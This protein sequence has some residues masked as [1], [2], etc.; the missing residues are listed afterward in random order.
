MC[1]YQLGRNILASGQG[2]F[3]YV[4]EGNEASARML[5]GLGFRSRAEP[6]V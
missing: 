1:V 2:L 6:A 3:G 4:V 5:T